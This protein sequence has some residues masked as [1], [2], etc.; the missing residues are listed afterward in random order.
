MLLPAA[1]WLLPALSPLVQGPSCTDL[2]PRAAQGQT[3]PEGGALVGTSVPRG[4][5]LAGRGKAALTSRV[6]GAGHDQAVIVSDGESLRT[7]AYSCGGAGG[8]GTPGSCGDPTPAGGTFAGFFGD[9]WFA[10]VLNDAGDV[11]F[12]ADVAGGAAPRALFL[13]RAST[14]ALEKVAAVGDVSPSGLA[15]T[16]LGPGRLDE[17]G[18]VIFLARTLPGTGAANELLARVGGALQLVAREGGAGPDGPYLSVAG[19]FQL[20][21]DGTS[22][23]AGPVPARDALGRVAHWGATAVTQLYGLVLQSPGQ[24]PVWLATFGQATPAGGTFST[25]GAPEFASNGELVFTAQFHVGS[26]TRWGL[27]A[28]TPGNLR[29]LLKSF[30]PIG[31][32]QCVGLERSRGPFRACGRGGEVAVWARIQRADLSLG[33]AHVLVHADGALEELA[34]TGQPAPGGGLIGALGRWPSLDAE[35]RVLESALVTGGPAAELVW[36]A[37]P[38]GRAVAFCEGKRSSLGCTPRIDAL[39]CASASAPFLVTASEVPSARTGLLLY[40]FGRAAL[41]FQGGTLCVANPRRAGP[42]A[43]SSGPLPSD[44]SGTL[45]FDFGARIA[46]GTDPALQAGASVAVQWFVRDPAD[47]LGFGSTLSDA[48]GFVIAP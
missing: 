38:C 23:A 11:L 8:S 30:D 26:S 9:P 3:G 36:L 25:F 7:I 42:P 34:E 17:H 40:G 22:V 45:A 44:C 32:S 39:G 16:A 15:L 10:P 29:C 20:F 33:E 35:G 6:Q 4:A 41:P 2:Y 13:F 5:T 47:P 21:P 14:G 37:A 27:F 43:L 28:G 46:S 24:A 31:A 12:L 48:Q 1:L 18:D 19:E